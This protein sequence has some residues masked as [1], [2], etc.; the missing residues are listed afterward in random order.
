[1]NRRHKT[2]LAVSLAVAGL[3]LLNGAT[4][5]QVLGIILVGGSLA[6]LIGSQFVLTGAMFVWRHRIWAAIIAAAGVG[7]LYG[8]IR[9]EDRQTERV[10]SE[11]PTPAS[12][13]DLSA[14]TV[15][16]TPSNVGTAIPMPAGAVSGDAAPV[17]TGDVFDQPA[18]Q[19]TALTTAIPAPPPGYVLEGDRNTPA[20]RARRGKAILKRN[21]CDDLVVYDRDEYAGGNQL[22]ID[23]LAEGAMVQLLGHVTVGDEDIIKTPNGQRGFVRPGCLEAIR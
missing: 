19:S 5:S 23:Q 7:A 18:H 11:T 20:R 4:I 15:S 13:I 21:T 9:Y 3:A 14:G 8:W 2:V 17:P 1:M 22:V 16:G 10:V 6:W 12:G